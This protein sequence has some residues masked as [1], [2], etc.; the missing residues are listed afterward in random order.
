MVT[1]TRLVWM[2]ARAFRFTNFGARILTTA[3]SCVSDCASSTDTVKEQLFV[4]PELSL[5]VQ[6]T[7]VAP[8][9]KVE[10]DAGSQTIVA[11]PQLSVAVG[12]A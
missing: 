4:L 8:R 5:A 12:G 2:G 9:T 7:E 1:T 6:V 10:P 3:K 11:A